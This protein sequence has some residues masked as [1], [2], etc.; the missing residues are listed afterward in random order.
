MK[1]HA[2]PA[3]CAGRRFRA[4]LAAVPLVACSADGLV[5]LGRGAP[6]PIFGEDGGRPVAAINSNGDD[7]QP[8]L[9]EDLLEIYFTSRRPGPGN[10]DVW[11]AK[12]RSRTV[13]FDLP[14]LV[15]EVSTEAQEVSPAIS[16]DGLTLWLGSDR[17][18]GLG[19][20]DIYQA[21][22]PSR[23]ATWGPLR[24]VTELNSSSDDVPR[25]PAQ[26]ERV[27]P[28][29]S[30]REGG[31]YQIYLAERP[32]RQAA[33][34]HIEPTLA[35]RQEG[36]GMAGGFLSEDGLELLFHREGDGGGDL[37]LAWRRSFE[38]PFEHEIAL[39]GVNGEA[40]ERDPWMNSDHTRFFFA[41]NRLAGKGFDIFATT[42]DL[43]A[44]E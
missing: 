25:P 1:P 3:A 27:M 37:W 17:A 34:D 10:G 26:Q 31:E 19:G 8:T 29:A 28:F 41:T 24:P 38:E 30:K 9:T 35:L 22:R 12:R 13:A 40:S 4:A 36:G 42:L 33:F 7:E 20:L 6:D 32:S 23:D 21:E 18:N 14:H 44:F 5:T 43:P 16:R 2:L 39:G 15:V 11:C